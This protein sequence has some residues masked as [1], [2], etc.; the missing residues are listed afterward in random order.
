MAEIIEFPVQN[1][2]ED[3]DELSRDELLT[4]LER[5]RAEIAALDEKEPKNM[6]SEAYETWAD[7]HEELEDQVDEILELLEDE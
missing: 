1:G 3:T 5:L 7:R 2:A 6:N 4:L